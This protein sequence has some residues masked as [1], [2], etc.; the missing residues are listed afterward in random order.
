MNKIT[1]MFETM[2][3]YSI[4]LAIIITVTTG[5]SSAIYTLTKSKITKKQ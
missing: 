1:C 2:Y 3:H 4:I 5:F